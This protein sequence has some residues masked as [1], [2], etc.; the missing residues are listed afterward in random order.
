MIVDHVVGISSRAAGAI[1]TKRAVYI[2]REMIGEIWDLKAALQTRLP[3]HD[4]PDKKEEKA[5]YC[6][7][8][9]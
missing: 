5:H 3:A 9:T 6:P 4:T 1:A 7:R 8:T 2:G